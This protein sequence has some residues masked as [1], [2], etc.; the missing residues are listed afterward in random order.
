MQKE[1]PT[2]TIQFLRLNLSLTLLGYEEKVCEPKFYLSLDHNP[3]KTTFTV[4]SYRRRR[5]PPI[6]DYGIRAINWIIWVG[7]GWK[8]PS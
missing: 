6:K 4:T 1:I 3:W 2:E 8:S 5:P 7:I